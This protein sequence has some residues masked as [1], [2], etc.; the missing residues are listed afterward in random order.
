MKTILN[1][2]KITTC[3]VLVIGG[4]TAGVFAAISSARSGAKT[5]LIEKNSMLGGTICVANVN[6]PGL[7]F[8]WGK[9]IIDG[10]CWEA[11]ER[12]AALGGAD[13][14]KIEYHPQRHWQQQILINRFTYTAVINEMLEEAGVITIT[15]AMITG[16]EE[17]KTEVKSIITEKSQITQIISNIL[18]DTTADGN[19]VQFAGYQL[20]KS[21]EQQPATL[22]NHILG[23]DINS[24]SKEEVL[25]KFKYESFP[26][27][28][29]AIDLYEYLSVKKINIHIPSKNADTSIGKTKLEFDALKLLKSIYIFY[30]K[31]KGLENLT[32]DFIAEET[33]VRETNRIIGETKITADE[34]ING[35]YYSDSVCYAFYPIDLHV[36]S[37][38]EQKFH[39]PDVIAKIP[40]TALIPKN[41]KRIICAGRMV[42]SDI[43]ANSGL[44]VQA[45]CMAMGQ[46]AGCAAAI[47]SQ[48]SLLI[49]DV[50]YEILC[51]Y[52]QKIGA[53]VPTK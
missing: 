35:Y 22:Q 8:A 38:I 34:Y 2:N 17:S 3:D 44:R 28:I 50:P 31:I 24:I 26:K 13:I 42:S 10:P 49:K 32:V 16:I 14:P 51:A 46:V 48:N 19:V 25:E 41:S 1:V 33:G 45:P 5:I 43:Y 15:N 53:I 37:G 36:L 4:G 18:I 39:K 20:D 47:A 30:K 29:I 12:T 23:Y 9:K 6:F 11:I 52:L 40:Y 27:Y 7:F 21:N